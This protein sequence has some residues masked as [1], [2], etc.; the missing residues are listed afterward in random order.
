MKYFLF[1]MLLIA[2]SGGLSQGTV[3]AQKFRVYTGYTTEKEGEALGGIAFQYGP[4]QLL[5]QGLAVSVKPGVE[6]APEF[7]LNNWGLLA[8]PAEGI[9]FSL[10]TIST[11]GIVSRVKDPVP[12]A[13]SPLRSPSLPQT[14]LYHRLQSV[15]AKTAPPAA[16]A[17]KFSTEIARW[18]TEFGIYVTLPQGFGEEQSVETLLPLYSVLTVHFPPLPRIRRWNISFFGGWSEV[19]PDEQD[20]WFRKRGWFY[21]EKTLFTAAEYAMQTKHSTLFVSGGAMK[22]PAGGFSGYVRAEGALTGRFGGVGAVAA[23]TDP[24]YISF[25]GK[26]QDIFRGQ[27]NP[28]LTLS[29]KKTVF[30]LGALADIRLRRD[31]AFAELPYTTETFK[32]EARLSAPLGR[33]TFRTELKDC[34][35]G[36]GFTPGG[37]FSPA[38]VSSTCFKVSGKT[39]FI[40]PY[41]SL[42]R[43]WSLEELFE[44]YPAAEGEKQKQSF[45]T[46][47]VFAAYPFSFLSVECTALY[48]ERISVQSRSIRLEPEC[49]FSFRSGKTAHSLAVTLAMAKGFNT[50]N[51]QFLFDASIGY[52]LNLSL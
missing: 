48:I 4:M 26:T 49:Y 24:Q 33:I 29:G 31:S 8:E 9:S 30:R 34:D 46:K 28:Y 32:L 3:S 41:G 38:P 51:D 5:A 47:V 7:A 6:K 36:S 39:D 2:L 20:V 27:L 23:C 42:R 12:A 22:H 18:V 17:L 11:G 35:A 25:S 52:S 37:V 43:N 16:G 1:F 50:K 15:S 14:G 45:T 19:S 10:G 21:G 13:W 44:V 40:P